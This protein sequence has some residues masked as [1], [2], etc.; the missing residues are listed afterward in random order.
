MENGQIGNLIPLE[1][2]TN[3]N[4]KKADYDK[5]IKKYSESNY[6]TTRS[7]SNRFPT[8]ESFDPNKRTKYLAKIFYESI[9]VLK[10]S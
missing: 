10:G 1:S 5:K 4:L 6:K 2:S 9:L 8:K 7:F 3:N